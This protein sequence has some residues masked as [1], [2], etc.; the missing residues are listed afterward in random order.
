MPRPLK[1]FLD[2]LLPV[3]VILVVFLGLYTLAKSL[4]PVAYGVF[5]K[6]TAKPAT[7]S[8]VVL[9]LIDDESVS[10]LES[11]FGPLFWRANA[12]N[13]IFQKLQVYNPAVMVFDADV[14]N[15]QR[16]GG[17]F[18][19]AFP[20]LIS[21]WDLNQET[22]S[23][24]DT[25]W[26]YSL[27]A[28]V[29]NLDLDEDGV[30]RRVK[31]FFRTPQAVFPALS[32][33]TAIE[34]LRVT[35]GEKG[36]AAQASLRNRPI[37]TRNTA[38]H[39]WEKS[40]PEGLLQRKDFMIR[41]YQLLPEGDPAVDKGARQSHPSIPLW[42]LFEDPS[43][44]KIS[45]SSLDPA[46][47]RD[48]IVILGTSSTAFKDYQKSPLA[49]H[50]L[51]ADIHATATDN[52]LFSQTLEKAPSLQQFFIML[53]FFFFTCILWV[54]F[55]NFTLKTL[56]TVS[57]MMLYLYIAYEQF[58][59]NGWVLDV[60]TPEM[61]VLMGVMVGSVLRIREDDH[62]VRAMEYTLSQLVSQS[63]F[64]EIERTGYKLEPGGQ[65]M[66]IT[67]LFVDMRNF[68]SLAENMTPMAVT[69][70]LNEFYTVVEK[71]V[72]MYG[73]TVDKFM[74]D[75]ILIMFGVPIPSETHADAA[76]DAA[77][78]ILRA[79]ETLSLRWWEETQIWLE[80]GVSLNSGPA[81]VGFLG[82]IYK[83]EYTAI[84]DTVNL[85]VRLQAET[86]RF[87]TRIIVSEYTVRRLTSPRHDL[88]RQLDQVTVRGR[89][90]A[91][92]VYT[93]NERLAVS[94]QKI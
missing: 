50:H 55:R 84:G 8:P 68:S 86:K 47:L 66:E 72:Y 63:V 89:E 33:A 19:Q 54:K 27:K 91:L 23:R 75:G 76:F 9:V 74:G 25:P 56:A 87:K 62:Q 15:D 14:V 5:M 94:I 39:M 57:L 17:S 42:Q 61:S 32:T 26:I 11:R 18:L 37:P 48:K 22:L 10:R 2:R 77:R 38:E 79:T 49:E 65:R 67:S 69:D 21:G 53:G 43:H 78:E 45:N 82:P 85:C 64:K 13:E 90:T 16:I 4:E 35:R 40:F 52:I 70:M 92:M 20:L 7:E 12:Y 83:L 1:F 30:V 58:A 34:Y 88:L 28:G 60:V 41:W 36:L 71:I 44:L 59:Q 73:G 3:L 6:M 31:R 93:L 80:I 46:F 51:G 24:T 81:F 29:V